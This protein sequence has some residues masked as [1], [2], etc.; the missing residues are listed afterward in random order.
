MSALFGIDELLSRVSE[1]TKNLPIPDG[2][3]SDRFTERN[4]RYYVTKGYVR[5]PVRQHGKS[6]WSENHVNDLV[7]IRR[8]QSAGQSLKQI[9]EPTITDTAPL[10]KAANLGINR[11]QLAH[12][13]ESVITEQSGWALQIS[14]NIQLSGFTDRRP[15]QEEMDRVTRALA[16]LII[17]NQP[18][19]DHQ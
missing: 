17:S 2:R 1:S 3:V 10:W 16:S 11:S 7:R 18:D 8:A 4:V 14:H 6:M 5:P 12:K 9:G 15:T 13:F 19:L